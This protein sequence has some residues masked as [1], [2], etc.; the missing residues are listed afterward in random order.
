MPDEKIIEETPVLL[1][2]KGTP[3]TEGHLL[4]IQKL[5]PGAEWTFN[6]TDLIWHSKDKAMP[7]LADIEAAIPEA[8]QDWQ[9]EQAKEELIQEKIRQMAI[10]A[11]KAEGRLDITTGKLAKGKE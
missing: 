6:G 11:L 8:V 1:D 9:D 3:L 2:R 7:K 5:V 10:E 4:A